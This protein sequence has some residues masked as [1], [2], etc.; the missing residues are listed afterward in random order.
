MVTDACLDN[1]V[2]YVCTLG[3][4]C[5]FIQDLFD[6]SI[7]MKRIDRGKSVDSVDDFEYE[8][9]TAWHEDFDTYHAVT[10]NP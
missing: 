3:Q 7:V 1:G 10:K 4:E 6:D 2:N 5:E 8:P 9:M